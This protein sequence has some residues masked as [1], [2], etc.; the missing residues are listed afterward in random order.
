MKRKGVA[1]ILGTIVFISILFSAIIPM[2]LVMQQADNVKI[3]D[4]EDTERVDK[5]GDMEDFTVLFYP[6]ND[7]SNQMYVRVKNT[8]DIEVHIT[9]LWIKNK[10]HIVDE[11]L[12]LGEETTI[13]PYTVD[14]EDNTT[15]PVKIIT[16]RGQIFPADMISL[17]FSDGQ[18]YS[19]TLGIN[20]YIVN[21]QGKYYVKVW[22][23]TWSDTWQSSG[24]DHD[25][26]QVYFEIDKVGYYDVEVRKNNSNGDHIIGS[27]TLVDINWPLSP[28][29]VFV[30]TSGL[31]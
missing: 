17:T 3:Q 23:S 31:D 25:D 4:I 1:V 24:I 12:E 11:E 15:Y 7:T 30:Y 28:P 19:P 13:G 16:E 21:D 18:W 22:N 9:R 2:K 5:E 8:G 20:V 29:I 14:L 27:P 10:K 6:Q 26:I